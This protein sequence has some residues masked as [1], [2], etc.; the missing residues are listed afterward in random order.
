[1]RSASRSIICRAWAGGC[2]TKTAGVT[3]LVTSPSWQPI[4]MRTCDENRFSRARRQ[5]T[6]SLPAVAGQVSQIWSQIAVIDPLA[7]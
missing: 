4:L 2:T 5:K 3:A 1:M 7:S 6:H